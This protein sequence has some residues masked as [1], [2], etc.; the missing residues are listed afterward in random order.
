ML[1]KAQLF[2]L[3]QEGENT[4]VEFKR[5][6]DLITARGKSEFIKDIIS[7]A[8]S[9]SNAGYIF[10][11]IDD[12]KKIVGIL[13]IEE[14][15]LQQIAHTYI[16]PSVALTCALVPVQSATSPELLVGI[17]KITPTQKPH[18]VARSIDQLHQNEVLVRQGSMVTRASPEEIIR[19][20]NQFATSF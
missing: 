11:G 6:L 9:V 8:N 16:N 3:I 18:K 10:V 19:M 5:E 2:S 4:T 20:N 7:I 12:D 15:R 1:S 17:V 14:E 13:D